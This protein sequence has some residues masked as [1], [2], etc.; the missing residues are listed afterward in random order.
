[1]GTRAQGLKRKA[2]DLSSENLP[3]DKVAGEG[4]PMKKSFSLFFG[5]PERTSWVGGSTGGVCPPPP[6]GYR[7]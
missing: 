4:K 5:G 3:N 1:M 6:L 2:D 7:N